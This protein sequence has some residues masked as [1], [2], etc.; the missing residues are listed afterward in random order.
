MIK[1]QDGSFIEMMQ[2]D[3]NPRPQRTV[4]TSG[5]SHIAFRVKNLDSAIEELDKHKV[6]WISEVLPAIGGGRLRT[7]V[8]PDG[9]MLQI[10]ERI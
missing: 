4:L 9:N 1:A 2:Q 7:F 8:D 6:K 3:E 10:V 5:L